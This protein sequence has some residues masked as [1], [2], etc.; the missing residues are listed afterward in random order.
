PIATPGKARQN[1]NS[2]VEANNIG[3][4]WNI[5][6]T[7][8]TAN[9]RHMVDTP[10]FGSSVSQALPFVGANPG[11]NG[12]AQLR[13]RATFAPARQARFADADN[14]IASISAI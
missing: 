12:E 9:L 7:V 14:P 8:I 3:V 13:L 5:A 2:R 1:P 6:N 10:L 4:V 11:K